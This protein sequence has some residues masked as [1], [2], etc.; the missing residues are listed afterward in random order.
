ML[1]PQ[2]MDMK[3]IEEL[4]ACLNGSGS[5]SEWTAAMELRRLG[6]EFPRLLRQKF[7]A[8]RSWKE[9]S[10]CVY[11]AMRYAKENEDA[12]ALGYAAIVDKAKGVRYRGAMLLAYSL[13]KDA[14][15]PLRSALATLAGGPGA[16]DLVAAIDAIKNEN[17]NYFL[18]RTHSGKVTLTID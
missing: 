10:V 17:H 18:D 7:H 9:R 6:A 13:R 15:S 3:R 4:I 11:H 8:S 12:L 1:E 16:D 2:I 14:L 5:D